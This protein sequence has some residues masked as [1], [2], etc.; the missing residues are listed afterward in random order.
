FRSPNSYAERF[1]SGPR[2]TPAVDENRVYAIG[3]TGFL[4]C[5]SVDTGELLWR[6]DLMADYHGR[7]MRY[8]V[9]FSP[10]VEGDLVVTT[11]GGPDGNAVV[12]FN[13]HTGAVV[14][15]ALDDPIGYSS[16]MAVT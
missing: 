4:Y 5:L 11:P 3:P 6:R 12:A 9:A 16:P 1:G 10:L 14:W 13:K 8:G 2:S 15:K 7:S